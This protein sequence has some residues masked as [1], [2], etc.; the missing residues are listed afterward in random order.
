MDS[1]QLGCW[2]CSPLL[3][4]ARLSFHHSVRPHIFFFSPLAE[5]SSPRNTIL[6]HALG[7]ICGYAAFVLTT[8]TGPPFGMHA[9]VYGPRILAAAL[10]LSATGALMVLFRVSHPPA[11]AKPSVHRWPRAK[12]QRP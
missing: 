8:A 4:A 3:R 10:S 6:G 2:H 12:A 11:G 9:G 5:A 1:S 7:F